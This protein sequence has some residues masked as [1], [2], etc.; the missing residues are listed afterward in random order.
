MA[1]FEHLMNSCDIG[2]LLDDIASA[3][4]TP[5]RAC[6]ALLLAA[7]GGI[8]AAVLAA[9]AAAPHGNA[10]H[11]DAQRVNTQ[12]APAQTQTPAPADESF[13]WHRLLSAD[14][15]SALKD[16]HFPLHEVLLFRDAEPAAAAV[17]D[18]ECYAPDGPAPRF[19]A[20]PPDEYLLCFKHDRLSR[21]EA[22]V[23]LSAAEAERV[24]ADACALWLKNAAQPPPEAGVCDGTDGTIRFGARLVADPDQAQIPLPQMMLS[25]T[26]DGA[27][28]Q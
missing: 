15:G 12:R 19:L 28:D 25:I 7:V 6:A 8:L 24:F 16:V 13:D 27:P 1:A 10:T 11:N 23:R 21:I 20:R 26:L 3:D 4:R 17:E 5:R 22:A 2:D 14:F 9:C 18:L